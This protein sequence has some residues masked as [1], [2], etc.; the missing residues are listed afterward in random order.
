MKTYLVG[1]AVRD[2][3]LGR[4]ASDR[5]WLATGT[6][7]EGLLGLG[8]KPV[9][10]AFG[11]FLHP[12]THEEYA[13]PRGPGG[14]LEGDLAA[15]D[16]TINAMARD[17][18]GHLIDPHGGE[19]DIE[20]RVL[21]HVGPAFAEDPA[22]IFRVARFAAELTELGFTVAAETSELMRA[23]VGE[24]GLRTLSPDRVWAE[25]AKLLSVGSPEA[26]VD[27]L[28]SCGAVDELLTDWA[29]P[30]G[31][32][33]L[34]LDYGGAREALAAAP[35]T[36]VA[37]LTAYLLGLRGTHGRLPGL[38]A[39]LRQCRLPKTALRLVEWSQDGPGGA[40]SL[41]ERS[42]EEVVGL[43]GRILRRRDSGELEVFVAVAAAAAPASGRVWGKEQTHSV[44]EV[45]RWVATEGR[46]GPEDEGVE[47]DVLAS[48]IRER[49]IAAVAAFLK[50]TAR[51]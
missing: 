19:A 38:T 4:P 14:T 1:G 40:S 6:D 27:V 5:D 33:P 21:R 16:L 11:V 22:R 30:D 26:G 35:P 9:G 3:L 51:D 8:F 32:A 42:P 13:L 37:R 47:G 24:R 39:F 18:N 48:R 2:G 17:G 31:A 44:R 50:G 7:E 12:E 49:Q 46:P 15:R 36:A 20:A 23:I 29:V 10:S 28:T 45:A 43:V 25:L 41:L 34:G